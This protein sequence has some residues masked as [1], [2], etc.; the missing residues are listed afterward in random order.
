MKV[1]LLLALALVPSLGGCATVEANAPVALY[2]KVDTHMA[3][4]VRAAIAAG[5]R[6]F[7]IEGPGGYAFAAAAIS[8]AI[9]RAGARLVV[10]GICQSACALIAISVPTRCLAAG[11]ELRMHAAYLRG[12]S[13]EANAALSSLVMQAIGV[14][15]ELAERT[16]TVI[17]LRALSAADLERL[18]IHPCGATP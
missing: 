15:R 1:A 2:G 10:S 5:R 11:A 6:D 3:D 18:D 9:R 16:K 17:N 14:P 8:G 4:Q 12:L 13:D 7:S